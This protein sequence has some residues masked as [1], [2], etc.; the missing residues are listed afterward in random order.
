M[1]F[2][3]CTLAITPDPYYYADVVIELE[4]GR[5]EVKMQLKITA[6]TNER[7]YKVR[8]SKERTIRRISNGKMYAY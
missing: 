3:R 1:V 7:K 5:P 4:I 2:F 8:K 6:D